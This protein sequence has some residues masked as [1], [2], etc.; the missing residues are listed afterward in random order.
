[1]EKRVLIC[2]NKE[3]WYDDRERDALLS[4]IRQQVAEFA[5]PEDTVAVRAQPTQRT[6]VRVLPDGTRCEESVEV[7]P[8]IRSLA[9]RMMTIVRRDGRDLLLANL[10]LQSRGLV[11][12]ARHRVQQ[13]L[14]RRAWEL[15]DKYMWGAGGAA[16]LS[17]LP[18][19]DLAAGC[20]ISTKMVVDLA[21]VYRQDVDLNAAV[22]LLAQLGKNLLAILGTSVAAPAVASAVASLLKT[23]PGIGTIAGGFLQG[24][25][26]ALVTRWI[27]AVFIEYF[28]GE[29]RQPEGG[30]TSLAR[31]EWERLTTV[32]Q[33]RQLILAARTK[34]T[35]PSE[36]DQT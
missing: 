35:D 36:E 15:V 8:D 29:M 16:A 4:Q 27:G 25:V 7:S 11:E 2:L 33:L 10:L 18:V 6:R 19:L 12:E 22:K 32:D 28:K 17:P 21:Q 23:V 13:S 14:D 31:R 34:L 3:D 9:E 26:Q 24:V 30:L 1:M 20:A 5:R